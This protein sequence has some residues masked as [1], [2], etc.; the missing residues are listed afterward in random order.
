M[1]PRSGTSDAG[2]LARGLD[3]LYNRGVTSPPSDTPPA[4]TPLTDEQRTIVAH[5]GGPA[6]VFAVAG[7][8]KTTAMT[9]R[10]ERLVREGVF[11][12]RAILATSFSKASVQDIKTALARWPHCGGVAVQT[13]HAVGWGL[14]KMAQRRGHLPGLALSSEEDSS[15]SQLLGRVLSRA[16]REKV[17][18]APELDELDRPDFLTYV[19]VMKANLWY[20]DL[21]RADLPP[22]ARAAAGQAPAPPG[23]P[24]YRELYGLYERVRVQE[25]VLTFD[26]M[27]LSG[28]ECLHR[29]PE[30]LAEARHRF[31]CVLVDEFQDVNRVQS[32]MLDLLTA[33][34]RSSQERNYMAIGDDD[35]T[36][37]EW[38]GADPSL[39][40]SFAQ[41]YGA[42]RYF[43]RDNFRSHAAPLALANRV[44]ERNRKREPKHLS[45]TRGFDG[46]VQ[47]HTE[48]SPERQGQHVAHLVQEAL[49]AGRGAG[50]I[51]I[52]VRLYAQTPYLEQA[53]LEAGLPYRVIGSSPFYARPE[54]VTLLDYLR[55]AQ[56][57][58]PAAS[59]GPPQRGGRRVSD[60]AVALASSPLP[61]GEGGEPQ[62]AGRGSLPAD[63]ETR[64]FRIANKPARYLSRAGSEAVAQSVRRG[65]T[66]TEALAEAAK[67]ASDHLSSRLLDLAETLTWLAGALDT[68]PAGA[69]LTLLDQKIGYT[70]YLRRSSGFPETGAARA[71]SVEAFLRYA[72]GQ[73]TPAALLAH[74]DDLAARGVGQNRTA[75]TDAVSLLTVFRAKGLQWPVVFV[76]DCNQ[77]IFPYGGPDEIEEERRLFYVALTRTQSRL[78]LHMVRT[79]APS[80]FLAEADWRDTLDAVGQVQ[81]LLARDPASWQTG[82]VLALARHTPALGLERYFGT[83]WKATPARTQAVAARLHALLDAAA[84]QNLSGPL[85][86]TESHRAPWAAL[87]PA[88]PPDPDA[89]PDLADHAPKPSEAAPMPGRTAFRAGGVHVG[90]RVHHPQHGVGVILAVRGDR[91]S[92]RLE[93]QFAR[94]KPVVLPAK[95]V[96]MVGA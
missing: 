81:A 36:I 96:E 8:G 22:A 26:D 37:Y 83:W 58:H 14:L 75:G 76:P 72:H 89:F 23:F 39:I 15:E 87:L 11:P 51:A 30:V 86:L 35:Q 34:D 60:G 64:W 27:L 28:W 74:L 67:N 62:R 12:A 53:L 91:L 19:G 17:S 29:F 78:H 9:Y 80:Q 54:V 73:P 16:W 66:L 50:E 59:G 2:S 3:F 70:D 38:R 77:G 90:G 40:L 43:I 44:I 65:S 49:T 20:A 46:D 56:E 79:E 84:R 63:W 52:L 88:P 1:R 10:I 13:L 93:I 4:D 41:R 95:F 31:Q 92:P 21:E 69:A 18:Y 24:W 45:L 71:A 48:D 85:G 47:V 25:H 55:L 94:G 82:D 6:L 33:P 5:D 61:V 42:A 32:E 7:A 57:T 68:L